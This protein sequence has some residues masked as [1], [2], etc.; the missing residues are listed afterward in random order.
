M[1][2]II[3]TIIMTR[4]LPA[5]GNC[6]IQGSFPAHSGICH[7]QARGQVLTLEELSCSLIFVSYLPA[8]FSTLVLHPQPTLRFSPYLAAWT[9]A[10]AFLGP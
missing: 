6:I 9:M 2:A 3:V 1:V 5:H 10:W 4:E 7:L 8:S